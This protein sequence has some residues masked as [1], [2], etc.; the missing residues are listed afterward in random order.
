MYLLQDAEIDPDEEFP[1]TH[2]ILNGPKWGDFQARAGHTKLYLPESML[3]KSTD[4]ILKLHGKLCQN[5]QIAENLNMTESEVIDG[6]L[7][8]VDIQEQEKILA[9]AIAQH[10]AQEK[11]KRREIYLADEESRVAGTGKQ[12]TDFNVK[13]VTSKMVY[14]QRAEWDRLKK[15]SNQETGAE[16]KPYSKAVFGRQMPQTA[17]PVNHGRTGG[18]ELLHDASTLPKEQPYP[19]VTVQA[20]AQQYPCSPGHAERVQA[21]YQHQDSRNTQDYDRDYRQ[22]HPNS[23]QSD[24][25]AGNH[26]QHRS[27][28]DQQQINTHLPGLQRQGS[29]PDCELQH[30]PPHDTYQDHPVLAVFPP[31]YDGVLRGPT[32]PHPPQPQ[33]HHHY[34][35]PHPAAMQNTADK[36]HRNNSPKVHPRRTAAE[37]QQ[38]VDQ[39]PDWLKTDNVVGV[40]IPGVCE[41]VTGIVKFVGV[42]QVKGVNQLLAGLQ[43]VSSILF[44]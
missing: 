41:P 13:D 24:L 43:L 44:K 2:I 32:Q 21:G 17:I 31:N 1:S 8:D 33:S 22:L 14:E 4:H 36:H 26:N 39:V 25:S 5:K 3:I 40:K 10:A 23:H 11:N 18:A 27:S 42:V 38:L 34:P 16:R 20:E 15:E 19:A 28:N 35:P 7:S 29:R 12:K 30:Y 37:K 6:G 9:E